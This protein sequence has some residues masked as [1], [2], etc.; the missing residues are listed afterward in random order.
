MKQQGLLRGIPAPFNHSV[1]GMQNAR[2]QSPVN[3]ATR[4]GDFALREERLI[5]FSAV[6]IDGPPR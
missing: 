3:S 1:Y 6:A 5:A 2:G 4:P